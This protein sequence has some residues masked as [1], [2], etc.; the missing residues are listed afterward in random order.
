MSVCC[1]ISCVYNMKPIKCNNKL[2]LAKR[3]FC[4]LRN[5]T[6]SNQNDSIE[7]AKS[8]DEMPGPRGLFGTGSLYK[9]LPFI[10]K[11]MIC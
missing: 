1:I 7:N 3:L 11:F 5:S 10:G 2:F 6:N 9:Y 8:F 4:Q